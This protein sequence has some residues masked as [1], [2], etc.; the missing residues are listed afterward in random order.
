MILDAGD[1]QT[2]HHAA[3]RLRQLLIGL[4]LRVVDGG[5]DQILQHLDVVSGDHLG[6][7]LERLNLFGA[8]HHD[9]D[10]AAAG[11]AL[12]L[13]LRHLLLQTLLH[14]L[15]LLHHLLNVHISSTSRISA[16][17]TSRSAWTP[18]SAIAFSRSADFLTAAGSA[19]AGFTSGL[20]GF[21]A[22]GRTAATAILRPAIWCAAAS[23][24]GR[25]RSNSS[26]SAR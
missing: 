12:D 7:D 2:T 24:Q 15:R 14:L 10:H 6:I 17:K 1:L 11:I 3:H 19:A 20:S 26:R 16:G 23:S 21:G 9:G 18:A 4:A 5:D 22:S 8:V 13:E 25:L